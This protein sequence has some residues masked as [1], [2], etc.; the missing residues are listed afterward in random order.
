MIF[1][2]STRERER[3]FRTG[4]TDPLY[5]FPPR[6]M[7]ECSSCDELF[8]DLAWCEWCRTFICPDCER[9]RVRLPTY[10]SSD[11]SELSDRQRFLVVSESQCHFW[12]TL[13]MR[14]AVRD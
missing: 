10:N 1:G 4:A 5:V 7:S 3:R 13:N 14:G 9:I 12:G 2:T 8:T 6:G 11:G